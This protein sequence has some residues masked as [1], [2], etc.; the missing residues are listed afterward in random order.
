MSIDKLFYP[1]GVAV[2]GSMSAGKLGYELARQ[3]VE[4][5]YCG[6]GR[7][8]Y[9]VN[10][11]AQG[12]GDVPG[13]S[14]VTAIGALVDLAVIAAPA[15][16]VAAA[17]EDCGRAEVGAAVVISAGFGEVGNTAGEAELRRIAG[18]YGITM[19][20]PNCA[21]MANT[22][23]RLYAT[24]ET[25]PPAGAVAL[26]SQS[27][28]LA[29]AVLSWAGEQGLGFSKFVSYGNRAGLDEI[30][31]LPYLATDPETRVVALYIESVADGRAFMDAL[32]ACAAVK[33]VV[34]IKSGR[35]GAGRRAAL[36]HTGSLAGS[37]AVYDAAIRS[38]GAIR[39]KTVEELFDVCKG[40]VAL[41]PVRGRRIAIVTNS[42]GPGVLAADVAE[43]S[44]LSVAEPSPGLRARL[45]EFLPANCSLKNPI[46]LTV[47]GTEA[48]YREALV[49][50]LSEYDA[51]LALNVATPYLDS[52][53]LARGVCDAA[54]QTGKP[55][56]ANFMAGPIVADALKYLAARGVPNYAIGERA[57]NVLAKM[58]GWWGKPDPLH[59]KH[60]HR[61]AGEE[62]GAW[63][64]SLLSGEGV[65]GEVPVLEPDAMRWLAENGIP[66]P[67]FRCAADA[68]GAVAACRELGYPAVMKVVSP[69]ILH[70][71]DR[72]GVV[73]NI[74][75]DEAAAA[76]FG[77]IRTGAAGADFRG[78]VIYRQVSGGQEVLFGLSRDPQFGPVVAFGLGGIYTEVL[79][80]V[81]LRV[82][83]ID[84]AEA[85]AMIREIRAFPLL[86][87]ARGRPGCDIE[88]LAA[89]LAAFSE[90][91]F[92]YPALREAD[93]N[94]VFALPQGLVVGDARLV[95]GD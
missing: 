6:A 88:A 42:G 30:E 23:H 87:G 25:R 73:L 84:C 81:A 9:A 63:G 37:D 61:F 27:G 32:A 34:V 14:S 52:V 86:A 2:I 57:V 53:A 82:A 43:E 68:A 18:Q 41:P 39:V 72:G 10:P 94:P 89:T 60:V 26:V 83:P 49:A 74:G 66:A 36:S 95:A 46:D 90:L 15:A 28:A 47:E 21:G 55:I 75:D 40:F 11:K 44:G 59:A 1:R 33:P 22:G 56:V 38:S 76:A 35:S 20:G 50:V 13:F 78:V 7:G 16:T 3:I 31:L 93:L 45:A 8:L 5:G 70:K 17:L 29:G 24:L 71:S 48:G 51:A 19:V 4:G 54:A 80:D 92:R 58:A 62:A 64:S 91:P 85:A 65:G 77:R 79:R 69:D 67:E 12:C